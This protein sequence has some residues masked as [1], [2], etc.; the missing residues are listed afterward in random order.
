RTP[1][2]NIEN[3]LSTSPDS[4]PKQ[5][6]I[7][8]YS[9]IVNKSSPTNVISENLNVGND[10]D[11]LEELEHNL[12]DNSRNTS[13]HLPQ[14]RVKLYCEKTFETWNKYQEVLNHYA[15]QNNFVIRKKRVDNS[16]DLR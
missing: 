10:N 7:N 11:E 14:V 1:F 12:K 16:H 2:T 4:H 8:D 13:Y 3:T 5:N 15:R 6:E 9:L